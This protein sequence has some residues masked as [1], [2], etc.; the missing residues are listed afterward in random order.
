M[1]F[2]TSTWMMIAFIVGMVL[3]VWKLYPFLTTKTLPDDD[4]TPQAK[5]KLLTI[6]ID[7]IARS[8]A[9]ITLNEL[10]EKVREH[11]SFDKEHFW[12]FNPNKLKHLLEYYYSKHPEI[13]SIADIYNHE[14]SN[15]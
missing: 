6:V 11:E 15:K 8:D 14:N 2:D 7:T 10:Y 13:N 5:E 3:S 9:T 1:N 12:R 4:N